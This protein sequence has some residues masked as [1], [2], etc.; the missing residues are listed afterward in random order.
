MLFFIFRKLG[1]RIQRELTAVL[2]L[3]D[4]NSAGAIP[5]GASE[6]EVSIQE[7]HLLTGEL[8]RLIQLRSESSR[9]LAMAEVAMQVAHDIRSPLSALDLVL[10]DLSY[11][12]EDKR[13]IL[14][15]AVTRIKDI[16]ND[17]LNKHRSSLDI[18]NRSEPQ[19]IP[20]LLDSLMTEKRLQFRSK[21]D[22]DLELQLDPTSYGSFAEADPVEF[23]RVVSNLINNAMEALADQGKVSV[24]IQRNQRLIELRIQDTGQGIPAS[25]L[26]SLGAR[27]T[28]HGKPEGSGLGLFHA[29]TCL[30]SWGGKLDIQSI[31]EPHPEPGTTVTLTLP[32][33]QTPE[34]FLSQLELP[35]ESTVV[36]LDDDP[37]IHGIWQQRLEEFV[38]QENGITLRHFSTPDE[39]KSFI[40]SQPARHSTTYLMDYELLGYQQNGLDLIEQFKLG[41]QSILVTSRFEERRIVER[42]TK[43]RV[44]LLPKSMT[45]YVPISLAPKKL[46]HDAILIDDDALVHLTWQNAAKHKD[47]SLRCYFSV[48]EFI[49][50]AGSLS[51]ETPLYIDAQL[52]NGMTGEKAGYQAYSLGFEILHLATGYE[53][54]PFAH[55]LAPQGPFTSIQGK[56]PIW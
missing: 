13:I 27:G 23:K 46:Q 26:Q 5:S 43:L 2:N 36:V 32:Q 44:R 24:H 18:P 52:G 41:P 53:P 3:I 16:A 7:F 31:P 35:R 14:R 51:T 47:K 33:A 45:S 34:W 11:F 55:L 40:Q 19:L 49:Q 56:D 28:T 22:V 25:I 4:P 8:T 50:D 15:S 20:A 10:Y 9:K 48:E 1:Q 17:L 37:S 21:R 54:E 6:T 30:E 12:P 38:L 42:A 29:R 39:L